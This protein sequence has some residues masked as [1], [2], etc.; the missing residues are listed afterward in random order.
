V[1]VPDDIELLIRGGAAGTFLI[2]AAVL[3]RDGEGRTV[4]RLGACFALA[5]AGRSLFT[6]PGLFIGALPWNAPLVLLCFGTT[7]FFWIFAEALF[8]D[9]F[10]M[11]RR[12][13][14]VGAIMLGL[15]A[16][17]FAGLLRG[18]PI[19]PAKT[20]HEAGECLLA[21]LALHV[22][23]RGRG[24]DLVE[25]RRRVRV[26]F[27]S[28][29]AL[30]LFVVATTEFAAPPTKFPDFVADLNVIG[31]FLVASGLAMSVVGI[32]SADIFAPD[33][34]QSSAQRNASSALV[35]DCL[36]GSESRLMTRLELLMT[37]ERAY[38]ESGLTIG[39][40]AS[41]LD[42]AEHELRRLI[43]GRLGWRNF[44]AYLNG[45]RLAEAREALADPTQ[46]DVPIS[47]I[48]LDAGFQSLG[49]FNRAFKLSEGATPTEFR[50]RAVG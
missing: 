39:R 45:W 6:D 9:G 37:S 8:D 26:L 41:R 17:I 44:N 16:V 35:I 36:D 22:A 31:L 49:P 33:A 27:V 15:G 23:W 2:L 21:L 47:T 4:S 34:G 42:A 10:R 7:A 1:Q 32:R 50:Q 11:R 13:L 14:A 40:L 3:L 19:G 12:H 25:P 20:I 30:L 46:A 24:A 29:T 5:A 43:N 18:A 38:R 28:A 48:A